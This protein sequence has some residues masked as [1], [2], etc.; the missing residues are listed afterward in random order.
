MSLQQSIFL[1][2]IAIEATHIT[3]MPTRFTSIPKMCDFL[4]EMMCTTTYHITVDC[5]LQFT[6]SM[7]QFPI[8]PQAQSIVM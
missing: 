8:L 5:N 7:P 1:E 4:C 6:D 3:S 2:P